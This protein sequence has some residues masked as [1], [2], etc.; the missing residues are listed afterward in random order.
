MATGDHTAASPD[1]ELPATL[2]QLF[3]ERYAAMVRLAHLLTGSNAVGE[4]LVQDSLA[5]M[6]RR[7]DRIDD[8]V[9]YLRTAVVNASR[10]WHRSR[11]REQRRLRVVAPVDENVGLEA[12]ELLDVLDDLP[13]GQRTAVV[14]RYY[15]GFSEAQIAEAMGCRPGT[16]KSHLHRGL[17]ALREVIER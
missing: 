13:H 10:S 11:R 2:E 5:R 8:P 14:L 3:V 4:D 7:W 9:A 17:A 1:V 16:V 15:E 6:Q 12:R